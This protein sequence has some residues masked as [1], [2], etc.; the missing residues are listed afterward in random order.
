M[1]FI[2]KDFAGE[3]ITFSAMVNSVRN[4]PQ[5]NNAEEF[6]QEVFAT[7]ADWVAPT[8]QDF[9][10]G[11]S[12][13]VIENTNTSVDEGLSLGLYGTG[14]WD[15]NFN[16]YTVGTGDSISFTPSDGWAYE[17]QETNA[18]GDVKTIVVLPNEKYEQNTEGTTVSLLRVQTPPIMALDDSTELG[19]MS[20]NIANGSSATGDNVAKTGCT[21]DKAT[22]YDVDVL[23]DDGTCEFAEWYESIPMWGWGIGGVAVLAMVMGMKKK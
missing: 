10:D 9:I 18:D 19:V 2:F 12:N 1:G 16:G 14:Q 20:I 23:I 17:V 13:T 21:D 3:P 4:K 6:N 22:N 5:D 15:S 8:F 7:E 11:T